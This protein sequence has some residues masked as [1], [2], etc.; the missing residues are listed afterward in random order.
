MGQAGTANVMGH[1]KLMTLSSH[2]MPRS[3]TGYTVT[4]QVSTFNTRGG[5]EGKAGKALPYHFCEPQGISL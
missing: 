2:K 5:I 4:L 1:I 3:G